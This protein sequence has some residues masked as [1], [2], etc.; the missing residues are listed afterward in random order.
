MLMRINRNKSFTLIELLV[1]VA[2][3]AVLVAILLPALSRARETART[4]VCL[5]NFR[6]IGLALNYF[7]SDNRDTYPGISEYNDSWNTLLAG[8]LGPQ[9]KYRFS[10]SAED[11]DI[12]VPEVLVCPSHQFKHLR[13]WRVASDYIANH[14][15]FWNYWFGAFPLYGS[16]PIRNSKITEPALTFLMIDGVDDPNPRA[17]VEVA[18]YRIWDLA[19]S[20][21]FVGLVHN[22]SA[23]MIFAD[24]HAEPRGLDRTANVAYDDTTNPET[25]YR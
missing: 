15:V 20:D 5:S 8:Y 10:W 22:K 3:I 17:D 9:K 21:R 12:T 13:L 2:I 6:Q 11:R 16:H 14:S 24:G 19:D 7:L 4:S 23:V 1:V 25:L 18:I